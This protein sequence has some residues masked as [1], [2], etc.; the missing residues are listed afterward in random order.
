MIQKR[1]HSSLFV[2]EGYRTTENARKP[3]IS[4]VMDVTVLFFY[5]VDYRLR[6]FTHECMSM[7]VKMEK[8]QGV[9]A[10]ARLAQFS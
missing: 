7:P 9:Q 10:I 4:G 3:E 1:S 8:D 2:I 6:L 5:F